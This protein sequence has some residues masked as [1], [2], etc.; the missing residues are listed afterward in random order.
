M[1]WIRFEVRDVVP[2]MQ[3]VDEFVHIR[4]HGKYRCATV[5]GHDTKAITRIFELA[6]YLPYTLK[7]HSIAGSLHFDVVDSL[8]ASRCIGLC[9]I[10][11]GGILCAQPSLR[12]FDDFNNV[13]AVIDLIGYTRRLGHVG[14]LPAHVGEVEIGN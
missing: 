5:A 12:C 13:Q 10:R 4:K 7:W 6:K 14:D 3:T 2:G 1:S 11:Q 9:R 8:M